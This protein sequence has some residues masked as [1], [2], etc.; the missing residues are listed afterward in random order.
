MVAGT[1]SP[2]GMDLHLLI[3]WFLNFQIVDLSL[4][5]LNSVNI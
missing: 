4:K 1:A 3:S 2:V 5:M